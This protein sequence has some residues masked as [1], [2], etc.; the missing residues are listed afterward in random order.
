MKQFKNLLVVVNGEGDVSRDQALQRAADL[1][2]QNNAHI[3]V[4]DVVSAP[5]DYLQT[6]KDIINA[7]EL[8]GLLVDERQKR[9]DAVIEPLIERGIKIN[10]EVVVGRDFIEII[11]QVLRNRHDVLI[12]VANDH[13]SSFDS[14]D[15]HLMRKCPQP[16]WLI[17]PQS[18]PP[19]HKILAAI[20]LAMEGTDEGKALNRLIM[21]LSASLARWENAELD[22]VCCWSLY[23]ETALRYSA[24]MKI[25]DEKLSAML[26]VE[27]ATY[28]NRLQ[29][30]V[31]DYDDVV[32]NSHMIKGSAKT[33]IAQFVREKRSDI[34]VMGTVG[35]TGIPGL[36]IG[37]TAET[38]LQQI[39][40]SVMTVKPDGFSSPIEL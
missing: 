23:G 20:D 6:Y 5:A 35:R 3:T 10:T 31:A 24:F 12:K 4:M 13:P 16:V 2:V 30:L 28:K 21:D 26:Q 34:V 29:Q 14:S 38:V 18:T 25:A 7:D 17:K 9:L 37:N 33:C 8:A 36:L 27:E 39:D 40:T 32:I 11:R 15:F 1:A 22:V 19:S